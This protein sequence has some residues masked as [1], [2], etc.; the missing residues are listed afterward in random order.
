MEPPASVAFEDALTPGEAAGAVGAG[1]D[2]AGPSVDDALAV[3]VGRTICSTPGGFGAV[4]AA[5]NVSPRARMPSPIR[6]PIV[7]ECAPG[8]PPKRAPKSCKAAPPKFEAAFPVQ[9][10]IRPRLLEG[11]VPAAVA[12]ANW[13]EAKEPAPCNAEAPPATEAAAKP[14]PPAMA[15]APA[16]APPN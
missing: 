2:G 1:A 16:A 10:T 4:M 11:A 8:L 15:A 3:G 7:P 5:S 13:A 9:V 12:C 6:P 14:A